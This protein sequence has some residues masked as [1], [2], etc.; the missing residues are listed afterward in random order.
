[1]R[2]VYKLPGEP[3]KKRLTSRCKISLFLGPPGLGFH[4]SASCLRI[5]A[6]LR[7]L[8]PTSC[9]LFL[10]LLGAHFVSSPGEPTKKRLTSRCKISLF[11]GPPGLGFHASASCLRIP[12]R[13]R[14]L[15]PTSC[16]LFLA[17]LGA[18]YGSSPG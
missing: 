12:A 9:R 10:A 15:S 7:S 3:T 8:S 1:M 5:P 6:R 11:L 4:A 18:H 14:S 17:L 2:E 13:L 16:R